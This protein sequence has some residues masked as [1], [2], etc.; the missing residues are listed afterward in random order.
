MLTTD[1][2]SSNR[3]IKWS[4]V[5]SA[6]F[7]LASLFAWGDTQ[8]SEVLIFCHVGKG[9]GAAKMT[10]ND[11]SKHLG[12]REGKQQTMKSNTK[13]GAAYTTWARFV[14]CLLQFPNQKRGG[15]GKY[16]FWR[17]AKNCTG[18]LSILEPGPLLCTYASS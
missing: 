3:F 2:H 12:G 5:Y 18:L 10:N 1:A 7:H 6:F 4:Q 13:Q 9:D 11:A 16:A 17:R 8:I 14:P 15:G